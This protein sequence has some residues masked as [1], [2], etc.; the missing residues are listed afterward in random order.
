MA[1][2]K[3]GAVTADPVA[4][5]VTARDYSAARDVQYQ[6]ELCSSC[7]L[8]VAAFVESEESSSVAE[9]GGATTG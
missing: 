2:E 7:L 6:T 9:N 3:C 8:E 1:C 5:F 4:V